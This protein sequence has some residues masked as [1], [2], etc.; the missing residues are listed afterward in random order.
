VRKH[1][2]ELLYEFLNKYTYDSSQAFWF[3][4]LLL[5]LHMLLNLCNSVRE[6][7]LHSALGC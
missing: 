5:L 6:T 7:T 2:Q 1:K 4:P 3:Q